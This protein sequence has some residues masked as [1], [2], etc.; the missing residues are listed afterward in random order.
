MKNLLTFFKEVNE[1]DVKTS[2]KTAGKIFF[3][4][5]NELGFFSECFFLSP[6]IDWVF[7]G[8]RQ[9]S[10]A[11]AGQKKP[12]FCNARPKFNAETEKKQKNK[13]SWPYTQTVFVFHCLHSLQKMSEGC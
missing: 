12:F 3:I 8:N 13:T 11:C 2:K 5:R 6:E 9:Q 7:F 10:N 1:G 4:S